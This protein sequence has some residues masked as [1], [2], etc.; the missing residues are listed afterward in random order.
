MK[1]N[2]DE[3]M[4]TGKEM[5]KLLEAFTYN[6][7]ITGSIERF[8]WFKAKR[9]VKKWK[10]LEKEQKTKNSVDTGTSM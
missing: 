10:R 2:K 7:F 1:K 4:T 6:Q 5:C 9:L 3:I 8:V